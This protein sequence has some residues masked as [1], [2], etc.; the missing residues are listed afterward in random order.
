MT[1]SQGVDEGQTEAC[2]DY[3]TSGERADRLL[4]DDA[5]LQGTTPP[6]DGAG[7]DA[8]TESDPNG[9]DAT[10]D[11]VDGGTVGGS[12]PL[13][14]PGWIAVVAVLAAAG[15]LARRRE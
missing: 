1:G 14:L 12:E 9:T 10:A 7:P 11:P 6:A 13:S 3:L 2:Y 8:G 5:A 15:L 4:T